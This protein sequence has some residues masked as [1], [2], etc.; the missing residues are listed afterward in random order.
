MKNNKKVY[1]EYD[2][3]RIYSKLKMITSTFAAIGMSLALFLGFVVTLTGHT[4]LDISSKVCL[5][6]FVLTLPSMLRNV[7]H[8]KTV[9]NKLRGN[10][11]D[12][13]EEDAV[14]QTVLPTE[15]QLWGF[16]LML[17]LLAAVILSLCILML[18]LMVSYYENIFLILFVL[19]G[20]LSLPVLAV[21]ITYIQLLSIVKNLRG[22]R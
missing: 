3:T 1:T 9:Q 8:Y 14:T 19:L 20:S 10:H 13:T 18:W 4:Q 16:I 15:K 17:A 7:K 5:I 21:M 2:Y 12:D 6:L 22:S 11:P